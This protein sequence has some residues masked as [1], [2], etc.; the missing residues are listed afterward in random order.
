MS[1]KNK[2]GRIQELLTFGNVLQYTELKK[3][4][5]PAGRWGSEIFSKKQHLTLELACGKGE[6]TLNLAERNPDRNFV[7]VDLKGPRIWLGAKR[8]IE[9]NLSNVRFLRAYIDH[10]DHFFSPGEVDEIWITFPDPFIKKMSRRSNRLTSPKFLN[11]YKKI[12]KK[13]G[14]IHLKTDSAIFFQFTLDSIE[15]EGGTLI[16][17]VDD[18][19]SDCPKEELLT[20]KTY[21][22]RSHLKA[23]QRIRYLAFQISD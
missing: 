19:Y 20:I 6:Y 5:Y 1:G 10:L 11:I 4:D 9:E 15:Q 2:T 21:Y 14:I 22:E 12:L 17:R 8:A 18:I 3:D 13:G 16:R 7:G 23:G